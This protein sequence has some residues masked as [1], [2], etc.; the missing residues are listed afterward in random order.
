MRSFL[1]LA[2]AFAVLSSPFGAPSGAMAG[3]KRTGFVGFT[4]SIW[5]G[6]AGILN[7]NTVCNTEFPGS[8]MCDTEEI[9]KTVNPPNPLDFF[10]AIGWVRPS[11]ADPELILTDSDADCDNWTSINGNGLALHSE[12]VSSRYGHIK[13]VPCN[14]ARPLACCIPE[15]KK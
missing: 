13:P 10:G 4:N 1:Y 15:R 7:Y 8:R 5:T 3:G 14:A 6:S 9:V 2:L 11:L 12:G